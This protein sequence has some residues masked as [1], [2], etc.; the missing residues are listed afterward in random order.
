ML[1]TTSIDKITQYT[2]LVNKIIPF[3]SSNNKMEKKAAC[4]I[5]YLLHFAINENKNSVLIQLNSGIENV[6]IY[7]TKEINDLINQTVSWTPD[8]PNVHYKLLDDIVRVITQTLLHK[9]NIAKFN[10]YLLNM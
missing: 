8:M 2:E 6:I 3:T 1:E 7:F 4:D 5:H 10:N 9:S